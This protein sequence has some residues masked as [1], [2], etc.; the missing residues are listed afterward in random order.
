M[1]LANQFAGFFT[2]NLC[3][4]LILIPGVHCYIV[5]VKHW[6]VKNDVVTASFW[7]FSELR[8]S[9]VKQVQTFGSLAYFNRYLK[10]S[11]G[12]IIHLNW[13]D[14]KLNKESENPKYCSISKN[15]VKYMELGQVFLIY[16]NK[17]AMEIVVIT[18]AASTLLKQHWICNLLLE[19][20]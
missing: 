17:K 5:L 10:R 19:I 8:A 9:N 18:H 12:P 13:T 14:V 4:L 15:K 6:I 3:D 11:F 7:A 2:F 20:A 16:P 1:L